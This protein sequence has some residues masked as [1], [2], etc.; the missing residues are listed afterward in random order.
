MRLL[1]VYG[2]EPSGHAA[3]AS[4]IE[5]AGRKAGFFVSRV[6]IAGDHHPAAGV[7]GGRG[8]HGLL[9]ACPAA[10]GALYRSERT[11]RILRGVRGAYLSL[12]GAAGARAAVRRERADLIV[13]P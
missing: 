9:R 3:A 7:G 10:W 13:C 4:A 8:Y 6:Q 11:R 5:E 1:L 12:G 2:Y